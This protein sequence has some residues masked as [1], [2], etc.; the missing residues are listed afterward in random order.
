MNKLLLIIAAACFCSCSIAQPVWDGTKDGVNTVVET[1]EA[2]AYTVWYDGVHVGI[3]G[4]EQLVTSVW[5]GG[6]NLIGDGVGV[7]E[8]AV[9]G[10]YGYVTDPFVSDEAIE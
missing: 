7:V 3:V 4:G 1:G 2:L 9:I 8:G 10:A 5:T 6:K